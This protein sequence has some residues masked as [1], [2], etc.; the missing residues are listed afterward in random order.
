MLTA[1]LAFTMSACHGEP[2]DTSPGVSLALARHRAAT[3]S[4]VRY[5]VDLTVPPRRD[6]PVTG[7]VTV[8][9]RLQHD[10]Q[11]VVLDFTGPPDGVT[12]VT[13]RDR[14]VD[15]QL[16]DGHLVAPAAQLGDDEKELTIAFTAGDGALNRQEDFLYSLFVPDRASSAFPCFDQPDL[17]ARFRLTL[18]VPAP[19]TAVANTAA[20]AVESAGASTTYRYRETLPIS[21]YLFAFAAGRFQVEEAA[22]DGRVMRLYHRETDPRTLDRNLDAIFDLHADALSWLEGYTD[23]P[24]PFGKFDVVAIPSFQYRGMEHPGAILY[25]ASTLFLDESATQEHRL[26][27]ASVIAHETAHM[28][29]GDLVTMRWFDDVWM[30]EVFANF[31]AAKIVN[32]AFPELHHDLRFFLA[33]HPAAYQVDRTAGANPIRQELENLNEAGTLYGAIIYQKAPIVMRHLEQLIGE[34]RMQE[35]L[36]RYLGDAAYGNAS[37]SDLIATLDPLTEDDLATWSRVWV[38]EPGRPTIEARRTVGPDGQ[39]ADLAI[40]QT[41]PAGGG[42]LWDQSLEVAI[43]TV[44]TVRLMPLRLRTAATDVPDAR[45]LPADGFVLPAADGVGYGHIRLDPQSRDYLEAHVTLIADPVLRG[46]AWNALWESVLHQELAPSRFLDAA[47]AALA[48]E[49]EEQVVAQLLGFTRTAYWR[50]LTV[51][52]RRERAAAVEQAL[53]SGVLRSAPMS[54]KAAFFDAF[55]SVALSHQAIGRLERIWAQRE[56]VAGLTIGERQQTAIA[57]ALAVR[58]VPETAAI[59][60]RQLERITD[61]DRRARFGFVMPAL[62]PDAAVRD[63]VFES[64]RAIENREREAWVLDAMAFLNHPLRAEHAERYVRP[65]L[66][67]VTELQRTGDIFFPLRWLHTLL[68]GHASPAVAQTVRRFLEGRPDYPPRLR[69]KIQQAADELFRAAD[70]VTTAR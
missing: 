12:A 47:V 35:G 43:G 7:T 13:S 29:F 21:T 44:D 26:D 11:P 66:E 50:F 25:R 53:W 3:V 56:G 18:T 64:F 51:E 52:Q 49:S 32:P 39:L 6:V 67:L 41:D 61:P 54:R 1:W 15:Y 70:I 34:E 57:E 38:E 46:V 16:Q 28:W 22:R 36:R 33:H 48:S 20:D 37:W 59:L 4:A 62:S 5:A 24:Y 8:R 2:V 69:G 14:P 19:W 10:R 55:T 45:G 31:M 42:R 63:S 40:V 27:R 58:G 23:I 68:D 65:G 17:K 30:K 9:F 60:E